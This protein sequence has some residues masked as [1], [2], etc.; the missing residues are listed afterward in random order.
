MLFGALLFQHLCI[1]ICIHPNFSTI[2]FAEHSSPENSSPE[3]SSLE[4]SSLENVSSE[5][6]NSSPGV[7][8]ECPDNSSPDNSSLGKFFAKKML[9]RMILRRKVLR[10]DDSSP[11]NFSPGYSRRRKILRRSILRPD[12]TSPDNSSPDNSSLGYFFAY[13]L[14]PFPGQFI[15]TGR[16]CPKSGRISNIVDFTYHLTTFWHKN[17]KKSILEEFFLKFLRPQN[18]SRNFFRNSRKFTLQNSKIQ[19]K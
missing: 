11:E 16:I 1:C 19:Q 10:S 8:E 14:R 6:E 2:C 13:S 5:A 4:D 9:C 12:D 7:S 15:P 18:S 17:G 3:D